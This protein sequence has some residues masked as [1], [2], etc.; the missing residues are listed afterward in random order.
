MLVVW[1]L[2]AIQ[3]LEAIQDYIADRRPAAAT[4]LAKRIF[5]QTKALLAKNPN[6]GRL[7]RVSGTRELVVSRTPYIVVY[8]VGARVEI[9]AIIHGARD[10][11]ESFS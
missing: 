3:D 5:D 1:T 11:P 8:R 2:P 6:V 10:W 9:L 7:G 4:H